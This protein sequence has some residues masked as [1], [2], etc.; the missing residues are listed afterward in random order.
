MEGFW[1]NLPNIIKVGSRSPWTIGVLFILVSTFL[2]WSFLDKANSYVQVIFVVL[3]FISGWR[4]IN[5]AVKK[6]SISP[7]QEM[8]ELDVPLQSESAKKKA[9]QFSECKITADL[10]DWYQGDSKRTTTK[11]CHTTR[12]IRAIVKS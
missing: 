6:D 3:F 1:S 12:K 5:L 7:L 9:I 2:G 11:I 8:R 4:L 10:T